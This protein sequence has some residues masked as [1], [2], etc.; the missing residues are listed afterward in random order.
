MRLKQEQPF[1]ASKLQRTYQILDSGA[2]RENITAFP[3][4]DTARMHMEV[5]RKLGAAQAFAGAEF[6]EYL[7]KGN[8]CIYFHRFFLFSAANEYSLFPPHGIPELRTSAFIIEAMDASSNKQAKNSQK[9]R[10]RVYAQ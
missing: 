4:L 7:T 9:K 2:I 10:R 6:F 5:L 8:R 3:L 1:C